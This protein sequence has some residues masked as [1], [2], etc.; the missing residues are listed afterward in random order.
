MNIPRFLHKW[1][2]AWAERHAKTHEP[3]VYIGGEADPYLIRW[4][5]IPRNPIF[6]IYLHELWRSDDDRALHDHPW[7]WCSIILR[8]EYWEVTPVAGALVQRHNIYKARSIRFRGAK[9]AH[10]LM[11]PNLYSGP[12][13]LFDDSGRIIGRTPKELVPARRPLTLFITGPRMREWGFHCPQGWR[14][15]RDFT[16]PADGGATVGRGCE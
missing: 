9:S 11:V 15:W 5:V 8:S 12:S 6:N 3:D 16:N 1:L 4:F 10:R 2:L 7:L 14:H 13:L